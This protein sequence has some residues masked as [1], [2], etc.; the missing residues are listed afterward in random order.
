[1]LGGTPRS[2]LI[3]TGPTATYLRVSLGLVCRGRLRMQILQCWDMPPRV[4]R[5]RS[6]R[7]AQ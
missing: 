3:Q 7:A 2:E 6:P 1:M 5:P 4:S